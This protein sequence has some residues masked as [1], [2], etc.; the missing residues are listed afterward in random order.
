ML[1]VASIVAF[2]Y[3]AILNATYL[4]FTAIA[5]RDVTRYR[6][7][8]SCAHAHLH[9]RGEDYRIAFV[10]DP[11]AW[12]E[13][14]EDLRSLRGQRAR[15]QRGL[16][17]SLWL[18]RRM[19]ANPRY[20]AAGLLAFP[21]FIVFELLGPIVELLGYAIVVV[22]AAVGA[23]SIA[24]LAVFFA[25]AVLVGFFLSLSALA[26]EEFSFRRYLRGREIG[27][28]LLAAVIENFGYRQLL[29]VWRTWALVDLARGG[30]GWGDMRRRGLGYAPAR[31]ASG[32][33]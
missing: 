23:L 20:G 31:G 26:L 14:P 32:G 9:E 7:A 33:R 22:S 3:F 2:G 15:W 1:T 17:Q 21:Y 29:A 4:L 24:F 30:P 13:A 10:P 16:G 5:W 25:A 6:P 12:T 18:H 11:V 27:R 28:L 8:R 19:A